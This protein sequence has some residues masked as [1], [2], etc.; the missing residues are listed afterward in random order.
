MTPNAIRWLHEWR[1]S[2]NLAVKARLPVARTY[3]MHART[4]F[5]N[6]KA[7]LR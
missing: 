4:C 7:E 2:A 5:A 3:A 6:F 1:A